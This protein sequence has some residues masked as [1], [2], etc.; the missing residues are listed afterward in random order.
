MD[1]I[2]PSVAVIV[3]AVI[4]IMRGQELELTKLARER[5]DHLVG[6]EIAACSMIL[7]AASRLVRNRSGRRQ[8]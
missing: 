5:A 7:S 2:A 6:G 3:D 8:S 1:K 4:V